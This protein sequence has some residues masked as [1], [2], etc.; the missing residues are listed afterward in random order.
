[1]AHASPSPKRRRR[2]GLL[3]GIPVGLLALLAIAAYVLVLTFPTWGRERTEQRV[4]GM[5]QSKLGEPVE[6]EHFEFDYRQVRMEGVSI[7]DDIVL[8]SVV[9]DL[10][11]ESVKDLHPRVVHV[12]IVGGRVEREIERIESLVDGLSSLGDDAAHTDGGGWRSR[13]SLMPETVTV[14]GVELLTR[15]K[16]MGIEG[17]ILADVDLSARTIDVAIASPEVRQGERSVRGRSVRVKTNYD[18]AYRPDFPLTA[19]LTGFSTRVTDEISLAEVTGSVTIEDA[20]L[21]TIEVDLGGGFGSEDDDGVGAASGTGEL[22]ALT[23]SFDRDLTRGEL[24]LDME[25][26]EL[27]KVPSVLER[28]PLVYS[29]SATVGGAV[30][31]SFKAGT[32]AANGSV[33]VDAINIR[34][35][36]LAKQVVR[37]VGFDLDFSAT[38]DPARRH[39]HLADFAVERN[40]VR[41]E[42]TGDLLHAPRREDRRYRVELEVFPVPCQQALDAVPAELA[43]S[44]QGV[45]VAGTFDARVAVAIDF[46]DLES[47]TLDHAIGLKKCR[48]K[49]VPGTLSPNRLDGPFTHR[50][51]MRD[52]RQRV[53]RMYPGSGSFTSIHQISPNMTAAVL[54]TEDGGFWRHKGFISSQFEVA[55]RRNLQAGRIRLGASTISMQMVKN[56][57]LSHERTL[58]RKFQELVLTW[59]VESVLDKNRIMELYLNAIEFGPGIYGVTRAAD[60]YFGKHPKEL[61]SREAAFLALMLPSPIKRHVHYCKGELSQRMDNKVDK[62]HGFMLSRN[63]ITAEEFA[64]GEAMPLVFD[65]SERDSEEACLGEIE[66]LMEAGESQR[67]LSGLLA[68]QAEG[69]EDDAPQRAAEAAEVAEA[70]PTPLPGVDDEPDF[71]PGN[72]DAPGIP[73]MDQDLERE[74]G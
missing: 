19:S 65:L 53:V 31:I 3:L 11:P 41:L 64:L 38:L 12:E 60:H 67:A 29:E 57:L 58:S 18:G 35:R 20:E 13:V 56:V 2:L 25:S 7:G 16:G 28:L 39:L 21:S 30:S 54:T 23:G 6:A 40:G 49:S 45:S 72:L 48:V 36:L 26:F 42:V 1:M 68:E 46:S 10:D 44:L 50:V 14:R 33:R 15:A 5:V 51:T 43:P 63:K 22:W 47:L 71:D 55:L 52:G 74:G 34:H 8:D 73:A 37:N 66:A 9:I 62:I 61:T 27:G 4:M 32:I 59:Y 70:G 17:T 69:Y 24:D